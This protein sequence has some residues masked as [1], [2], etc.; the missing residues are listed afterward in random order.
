[1]T[2]QEIINKVNSLYPHGESQTTVIDHINNAQAELSNYIGKLI[3]VNTITT[4]SGQDQYSYPTGINDVSE[5]K[6]LDIS[7]TPTPQTRYDYIRYDY[8]PMDDTI[9]K[10]YS[11]TQVYDAS[12]NKSFVIYPIPLEADKKIRITYRKKLA[13]CTVSTLANEPEFDSRF[14]NLIVFY[15]CYMICSS[16]ASPDTIQADSF[17]LK[18]EE[19]I[20]DIWR[21]NMT[22]E[23]E[24]PRT[25]K[26]NDFWRR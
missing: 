26:D 7:T 19:G 13:N 4:V 2:F 12:G 20:N 14:H 25:R 18:Y 3:T 9:P 11:Y 15:C 23:I 5:I 22:Q 8:A 24:S 1:M 21:L 17:K 10:T 6:Y 16:G